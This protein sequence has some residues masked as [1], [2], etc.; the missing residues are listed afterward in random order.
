M[1]GVAYV[2][3]AHTGPS[4]VAA[5]VRRVRQLSPLAHV[6]VRSAGTLLSDA[7]AADLGIALLRSEV[8]VQWGDW[9]LTA[10][11]V[12]ALTTAQRLWDPD[13]VVLVSGQ[14]HPVTDLAVWESGLV[15]VDAVLRRDPRDHSGRWR[16][17]W[18]VLPAQDV[19]GPVW[20]GLAGA[21]RRLPLPG[22]VDRAGGRTWV[23]HH[24]R[25]EPPPLPYVKGSFWCVL[26]RA[27]LTAVAEAASDPD[28]GGWFATTLLP[29]EAF[30]HSVLAAR[31]D[32][33]TVAGATSFT[34]FPTVA[35]A[36]PRVLAADD[37]DAAVASGAPFARK[38]AAV[39]DGFTRRV[40]AAVDA[41]A[42]ASLRPPA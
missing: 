36:H 11:A 3:M 4:E 17:C 1:G 31:P 41:L 21:T 38:V 10:A 32:L 37:A 26:S 5:R 42:R 18:H 29:D 22:G 33:R 9:S 23:A 39:Q 28:V 40:D 27:A 35:S 19:L 16:S 2:V 30:V 14:D 13:H 34:V 24:P 12:E 15:G 7:D 6:L 25:P 20:A 8:R